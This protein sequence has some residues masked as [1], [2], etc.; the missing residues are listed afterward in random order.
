MTIGDANSNISLLVVTLCTMIRENFA[1]IKAK[2]GAF[3]RL[4]SRTPG[5]SFGSAY[6]CTFYS[7]PDCIPVGM[8]TIISIATDYY[9]FAI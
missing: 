8:K 6:S 2:T 5:E 4:N 3:V 9:G 7:N 1:L